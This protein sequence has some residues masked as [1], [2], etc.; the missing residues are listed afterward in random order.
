MLWVDI[1]WLL[2]FSS[3]SQER[4]KIM[5]RLLPKV[6]LLSFSVINR[7]PSSSSHLLYRL[8][9]PHLPAFSHTDTV[10]RLILSPTLLSIPLSIHLSPSLLS[11][12]LPRLDIPVS[13]LPLRSLTL[14]P[15]TESVNC[16]ALNTRVFLGLTARGR[17]K[18]RSR[19]EERRKKSKQQ[20]L[21]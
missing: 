18:W 11:L 13:L 21:T 14:L 19:C 12:S 7:G 8:L 16:V 10:S 9:S 3:E 2:I 4:K 5:L 6:F 1:W 17:G 20:C 15:A